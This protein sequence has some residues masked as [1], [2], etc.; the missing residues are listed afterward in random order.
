MGWTVEHNTA[1]ADNVV[2]C[3]WFKGFIY[4]FTRGVGVWRRPVAGPPWVQVFAGGGIGWYWEADDALYCGAAGAI[5]DEIWRSEDGVAWVQDVD[6]S[7][8]FGLQ[9][10]YHSWSAIGGYGD[11]L[12][13]A[14]YDAT[15]PT[16]FFYRRN[17]A[18]VWAAF[19]APH[20]GV[21]GVTNQGIIGFGGEVYWTNAN[22]ARYWDGAAWSLE[23]T[24]NG[25]GGDYMS[26]I[27]NILYV[28]TSTSHSLV[29]GYYW[30]T[31]AVTN[32]SWIN[33]PVADNT[34]SCKPLCEGADGGI[35]TLTDNTG[36]TEIRIYQ[37]VGPQLNLIGYETL[38]LSAGLGGI[39][40]LPDGTMYFGQR[41]AGV[42]KFYAFV[43]TYTVT[44]GGLYPQAMDCDGDGDQLYLGLYD[45]ATAQVI[46][47]SVP[48]PLDG[49]LSVG[50]AMF[51]PGAGSTRVN[52]QCSV[53]GDQLVIAGEFAALDDQ[54]R[55]SYDAGLT[56]VDLDRG[57]WNADIAQPLEINPASIDGVALCPGEVMVC[58]DTA[59]DITE[60]F[61]AGATAWRINN[62]VIG[63]TPGSMALLPNG[64]EMIIGDDA[65][66]RVDYSPNRGVTLTNITGAFAG[67]GNVAALEIT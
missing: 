14:N 58:L 48:T 22:N 7:V 41:D 64:D 10:G 16:T 9:G 8:A 46:L 20:A 15:V 66:N 35:Y 13:I 24:L 50:S 39:C 2:R 36:T 47:I 52:V 31:A 25:Q 3:I 55:A 56:W 38:G 27:N 17:L 44:P 60:T 11:Y 40:T 5:D 21:D 34:W 26:I 1:V 65:A 42:I 6:L 4:V 61:N 28:A 45:T 59:T 43:G 51:T 49:A 53:V 23:P 62:A 37:L 67:G 18:G 33:L 57:D 63:Y 19:G 54:V 32:W 30:K 29:G 12:Y